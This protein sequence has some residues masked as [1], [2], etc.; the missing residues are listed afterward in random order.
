MAL[1]FGFA[2]THRI[3]AGRFTGLVTDEELTN[4][5]RMAT[6]MVEALDPLAGITDFSGVETLEVTPET[7][8]TLASFP[9]IMPQRNRPRIVVASTDSTFEMAQNFKLEGGATR[10]NLHVVRTIQEAWAIIGVHEPEFKPIPEAL[11]KSDRFKFRHDTGRKGAA[12][13]KK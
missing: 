12:G 4:F 13:G 1:H 3:L 7:I 8:R 6:L 9:P 10:P 5:Y 11:E 2:P